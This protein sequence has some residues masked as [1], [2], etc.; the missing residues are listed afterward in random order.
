MAHLAACLSASSHEILHELETTRRH[1]K[2]SQELDNEADSPR[3]TNAI[4]G[5]G[6]MT[7]GKWGNKKTFAEIYH[8]DKSYLQR[9]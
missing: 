7:K 6:Y 9:V 5:H 8:K 4:R 2:P 1:T 3:L